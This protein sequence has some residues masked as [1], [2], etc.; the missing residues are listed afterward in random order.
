MYVVG[1]GADTVFQYTLS[2][3]WDVSTA[4]YASKS[5]LV[6]GQDTSPQGLFFK[7]DGLAMYVVGATNDAVFQYNLSTAWDV[8]TASY[9]SISV[10]VVMFE[11]ASS[12]LCFNTAGT[13]MYITGNSSDSV[14]QFNTE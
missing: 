14:F 2:T 12:G 3:A 13:R 11:T 5:F 8:S 1:Q 7:S 9:A 10:S 4:S 6:S